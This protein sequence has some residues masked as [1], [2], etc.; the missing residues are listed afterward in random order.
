MLCR[1]SLFFQH[2][3]EIESSLAGNATVRGAKAKMHGP[4]LE[5]LVRVEVKT[6]RH[7]AVAI[8]PF[9]AHSDTG[10]CIRRFEQSCNALVIAVKSNLSTSGTHDCLLTFGHQCRD[11]LDA[12][13]VVILAKA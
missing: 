10:R 2:F 13:L 6:L 11:N 8:V 5:S 4:H 9:N 3:C 12:K 7:T 1:A